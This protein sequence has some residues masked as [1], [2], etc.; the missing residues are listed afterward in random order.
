MLKMVHFSWLFITL[1]AFL[2]DFPSNS[3]CFFTVLQSIQ[4]KVKHSAIMDSRH[5]GDVIT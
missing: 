2:I 1:K 4:D 3:I 5:T